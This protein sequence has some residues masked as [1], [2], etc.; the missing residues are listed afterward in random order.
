MKNNLLAKTVLFMTAA[1]M[2]VSLTACG[3]STDKKTTSSTSA[4]AESAESSISETA[5]GGWEA[6]SGELS[7][8]KNKE[9]KEAF[10]K[11][12]DGLTGYSYD[13]IALIGSQVVSGTNYAI[14]CKGE[15][16]VPDALPNY[17]IVYV[18][19]NLDGK[20]EILGSK[21]LVSGDDPEN[22]LGAFTVNEGEAA[23][24]KN[25]DAKAAFDKAFEGMTGASYDA[26]AYLGSQVVEGTNYL[27]L[28][29][30]TP[31]AQDPEVQFD[32]I[33]AYEDLKGNVKLDDIQT[34]ELGDMDEAQA[35]TEASES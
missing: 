29:R 7:L 16:V 24:D 17:E 32:V 1:S 22:A 5:D 27:A 26:V 8:D 2:A 11:A 23:L 15:V 28:F 10:E 21:I 14:L 30:E 9:A 3:S 12:V 25:T 33:T 20:A 19:E 6:N 4:A 35:E 13:P 31:A 34:V 18:Y